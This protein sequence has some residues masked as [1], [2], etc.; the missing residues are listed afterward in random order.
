MKL[1]SLNTWSGRAGKE[2]LLNF[3]SHHAKTDIFCLQEI[4][5]GGHEHAKK[6]HAMKGCVTTLISDISKILNDHTVFFYPF[7]EDWFGSAIFIKKEFG[8]VEEGEI[9]V[10]GKKEDS[11]DLQ[12]VNHARN[13][14]YITIQ[15]PKGLRT[16]VNF[17]GLWN[18]QGKSDTAER[19]LQS[20]NIA[21]FLKTLSHPYVLCGDF[22]LLPET[23][24]LKKLENLGLRNLIKEFAITSTRSSHYQ[25]PLKFADYTLVTS[26]ITVKDFK[27][28]PDEVSDHLAMYLE[29]N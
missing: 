14:Q 29:F 15:T 21:N 2:E 18:G 20:D 11:W 8:I 17:H 25:K 28:L 6:W 10:H 24:S 9:F 26:E 19:L 22:N 4:W 16:I 23:E 7:Y 3:F 5:E 1:I 27:V 12:D 13:I